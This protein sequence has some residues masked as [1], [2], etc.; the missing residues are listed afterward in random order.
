VEED[1]DEGQVSCRAVELMM[2]MMMI[3]RYGRI[4]FDVSVNISF[5]LRLCVYIKM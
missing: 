4:H 2:M 1:F 3:L 5:M